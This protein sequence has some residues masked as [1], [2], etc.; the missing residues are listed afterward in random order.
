MT[1]Y[2]PDISPITS[3]VDHWSSRAD[4][5]V[6]R[7]FPKARNQPKGVAYAVQTTIKHDDITN[8]VTGVVPVI[9]PTLWER[10]ERLGSK[11]GLNVQNE[12]LFWSALGADAVAW[13][14]ERTDE[15]REIAHLWRVSDILSS[16]PDLSIQP[17][18][19]ALKIDN[20][21]PQKTSTLLSALSGIDR[22]RLAKFQPQ[23]AQILRACLKNADDAVRSQAVSSLCALDDVEAVAVLRDAAAHE[24]DP[25]VLDSLK[26]E[27]EQRTH[28]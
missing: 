11:T 4:D 19:T 2:P 17:M 23:I 12:R 6:I 5:T 24:T 21:S 3:V 20:A 18:I 22:D 15:H 16:I 28:A 27:L 1:T 10:F 25:D 13:L 7:R 9:A 8:T 14:I 26:Y